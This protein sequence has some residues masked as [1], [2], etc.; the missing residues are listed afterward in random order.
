MATA[1]PQ[2]VSKTVQKVGKS[3]GYF[4]NRMRLLVINAHPA[5]NYRERKQILVSNFLL[6][7]CDKQLATSLKIATISTS[8]KAE[9]KTTKCKFAINNARIKKSYLNYLCIDYANKHFERE[10]T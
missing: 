8:N 4:M 3:I 10:A 5:F 9:H 6:G 1:R 7:L 2:H